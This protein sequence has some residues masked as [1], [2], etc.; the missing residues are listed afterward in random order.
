MCVCVCVW[1]WVGVGGGGWVSGWGWVGE[2]VGGRILPDGQVVTF[3]AVQPG[4]GPFPGR[5]NWW[6]GF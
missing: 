2:W 4:L 1:V 6:R 5:V 3:E